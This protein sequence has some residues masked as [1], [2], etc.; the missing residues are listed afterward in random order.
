MGH[1]ASETAVLYGKGEWEREWEMES[2]SESR[3]SPSA[4]RLPKFMELVND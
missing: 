3:G 4:D 2:Q 1:L